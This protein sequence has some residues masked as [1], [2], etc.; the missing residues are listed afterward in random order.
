MA[1]SGKVWQVIDHQ[2]LN[3]QE[4]LNVYFFA[5][6]DGDGTAEDVRSA[7]DIVLM[8]VIK[9]MQS[10]DLMHTLTEVL[11]LFDEADFDLFATGTPGTVANE[12]L[13]NTDAINFT[14]KP[15]SRSVR[16]GSKRIAGIPEGATSNNVVNEE[17]YLPLVEDAR[18]ALEG[19]II[20]GD[21][22]AVEYRPVIVKRIPYTAP[23]GNP[24]YRLPV[25]GSEANVVAV[26]AVLTK[27]VMSHQTSRSG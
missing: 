12:S 22:L 4:M 6:D 15:A 8:D 24:A 26:Q 2:S 13:P 19:N 27:L 10:E 25:S 1:Y 3:N 7:Y 17:T 18:I 21:G 23:S 9:D 5:N 20:N 16:P 11:A 14:L